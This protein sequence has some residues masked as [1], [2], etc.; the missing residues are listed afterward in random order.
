MNLLEDQPN[1][2]NISKKFWTTDRIVSVSAICISLMTL[3]TFVNQNRLLQ[4]QAAL[5]VLPYLAISSSYSNGA[6]PS[7]KLQI[8]NRGVGPAIIESQEIRYQDKVYDT[9]F[10]DFLAEQIPALDSAENISR[11]SFEFGHVLPSGEELNLF[12]I[13]DNLD[14]V[15][16]VAGT[17]EQLEASGLEYDVVYRSIYGERWKITESSDLPIELSEIK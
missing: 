11:S 14:M 12:G 10:F 5:S 2:Q 16:L 17:L 3:L 13:Y 6:D 1:T 15:N 7:I 8:V 4:K 9:E